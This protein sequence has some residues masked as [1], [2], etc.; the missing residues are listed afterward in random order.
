MPKLKPGTISPTTEEDVAIT[1]AAMQDP[2]ACPYSDAEW[3]AVKPVHGRDWSAGS[4]SKVVTSLRLDR[5]LLQAFK[6]TGDGWETV[7]NDALREWA[8]N[9]HMISD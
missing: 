5:D 1:R 2:D 9:H 6:D 7:L 4:G 3:E 8:K